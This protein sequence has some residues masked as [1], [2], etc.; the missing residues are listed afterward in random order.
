MECWELDQPQILAFE[1]CSQEFSRHSFEIERQ[2][3]CQQ[4]PQPSRLPSFSLHRK[5]NMATLSSRSW[6]L[7]MF[8]V[9]VLF[10]LWRLRSPAEA[11]NFLLSHIDYSKYLQIQADIDAQKRKGKYLSVTV[12][13]RRDMGL[14]SVLC[15]LLDVYTAI[16]LSARRYQ[17]EHSLV[18]SETRSITK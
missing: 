9:G 2:R 3:G 1:F 10:F 17:D 14:C 13:H 7:A 15:Q 11:D 16:I 18:F 5:G 8:L 12:V 4:Q 6:I